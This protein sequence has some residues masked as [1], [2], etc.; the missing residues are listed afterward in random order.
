MNEVKI[1]IFDIP[2]SN[3]KYMG[4]SHSFHEYRVE[5]QKWEWLVRSAIKKRPNRPFKKAEVII[6]YFF[7]DRKRRDPDNYSG[8][9]LLDGLTKCGI[10][11]DDSFENIQ[12][13]LKGNYDKKNPRTEITVKEVN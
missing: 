12:L 11:E 9:F 10:L 2:P 5:K 1:I 4:N 8:K 6:E 13:N 7:G 3:N